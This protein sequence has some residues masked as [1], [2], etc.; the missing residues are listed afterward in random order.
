MKVTF[1][2][3]V[4]NT[5][6]RI[7]RICINSILHAANNK[8]DVVIIDDGS[9][10]IETIEFLSRC[11]K[12]EYQNIRV[13][14]NLENSGVSYSL[15]K[16]I[17]SANGDYIAPIDHDDLVI[18]SGF[19]IAM[20]HI[21]YF[22]S[23]WVYTNELQ[24][25]T[26]GYLIRSLHKPAYSKQ[27]LRSIMYINHLQIFSKDL[28]DSIGGYRD[29]LEGSQDHDLALRMTELYEPL[30]VPSFAYQW[31]IMKETQSR[32]DWKVSEGSV[33]SSIRALSDHYQAIGKTAVIE[34]AKDG[35]SVYKSRIKSSDSPS[36]SIVIPAKLGTT[37][38]VSG[39]QIAVL[40]NCLESIRNT[41]YGS[42][43]TKTPQYSVECILVINEDDDQ[44]AGDLLLNEFKLHGKT[45]KDSGKFNFSRKCNLGA[46]HSSGDILVFLNDDT[47]ILTNNWLEDVASLLTDDDVACLGAMLLD[48]DGT[49]QS[50]GDNVGLA[51]ATHYDPHPDPMTEGDPMH[52]YWADHETT[53]VTGAF[54]CCRK[55]RFLDLEGFKEV[56]SNSFQDVDFCLRARAQK[57]RCLIS[58]HIKIVH[59]ESSS[60]NPE[61]DIETLEALRSFH[62]RLI[63]GADEYHLW[64]YQPVR[65]NP[66]TPTGI[67]HKIVQIRNIMYLLLR[68]IRRLS[69]APRER[70]DRMIK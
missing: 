36:F 17:V 8:H 20:K 28:F 56:F 12:S 37:R 7:L 65:V 26:K 23:Q 67:I 62:H 16:G 6:Y 9:T 43:D 35:F 48:P 60:R 53:S 58:P 44:E 24:I 27:L 13:L 11:N 31:R 38:I 51:S 64:A 49:V 54:F 5:D 55:Q 30:H 22:N 29:G 2:V 19:E 40:E 50:C 18:P 33:A 61:V 45:I 15:N 14:K 4:F 46:A 66:L 69:P 10:N 39:K 34:A 42:G 68:S 70:F 57:L 1:V 32:H 21:L 63:S 47:E 59:Y 41:I 25:D 3:P 52:R